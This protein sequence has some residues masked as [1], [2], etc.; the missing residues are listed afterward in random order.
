MVRAIFRLV[1]G[2]V[3]WATCGSTV[4]GAA[5]G[6]DRWNAP[7]GGT[8]S[9]NFTVVSDYSFAGISQTQRQP[10]FQP[11]LYY[12]TPPVSENVQLWAYLALWGSNIDFPAT[13]PG[14]EID[15]LGGLKLRAFDR[16]LGVD[17]GYV[18][19]FYPGVPAS[20]AYDYGDFVLSVGYD[21]DLLQLNGRVRYSPNSFGASGAAWNKRAQIVVPLPFLR[22]NEN[23]SFKGYG[24][25]GNQWV[26][27]Y[28]RYG[29][30]SSDYWYWQT[31]LII[32][33]YGVD[34]TFA[35][36]DT[37]IDIAGCGNTTNCQGRMIVG[38]SKTF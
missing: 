13:G 18:R 33:A 16:R 24:T 4:A 25:L 38:L 19:Y 11:G 1:S 27:R 30:P 12:R 34:V 37:S 17:L 8:F 21:F 2:I 3:L 35:Y 7:L 36:A 28:L 26:E 20:L 14:V 9:A 10:A 23:I 29:I 15:A 31:G 22:V 6:E 32:S 5:D